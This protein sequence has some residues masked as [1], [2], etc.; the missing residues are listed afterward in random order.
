LNL[1][2]QLGALRIAAE[3]V[4]PAC[5]SFHVPWVY[6]GFQGASS[7]LTSVFEDEKK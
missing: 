7:A 6:D 4:P 2:Y 5:A 3:Q 1:I